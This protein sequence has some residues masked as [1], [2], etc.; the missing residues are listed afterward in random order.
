MV[1]GHWCLFDSHA[2]R[3]QIFIKFVNMATHRE[4]KWSNKVII[5][6]NRNH[7]NAYHERCI[8]NNV[9]HLFILRIILIPEREKQDNVARKYSLEMPVF[10]P[11]SNLLPFHVYWRLFHAMTWLF[12]ERCTGLIATLKNRNFYRFNSGSA[13]MFHYLF[14]AILIYL[15]FSFILIFN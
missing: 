3:L 5:Y 4:A 8:L 14:M 10:I 1:R 12:A 11:D 9:Y 6:I 13:C 2:E 7:F 15:H